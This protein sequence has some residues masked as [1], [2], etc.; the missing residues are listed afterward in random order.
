MKQLKPREKFLIGLLMAV[1][2][3]VL[4]IQLGGDN[5]FVGDT[6]VAGEPLPPVGESPIVRMDLLAVDA[7]P[8]DPSGRNLFAYYVPPKPPPKKRP[9]RKPP[10]P[11]V[12]GSQTAIVVGPGVKP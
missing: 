5:P 8:Y 4:Y 2:V 11:T 6:A 9:P 1:G 12:R 10:R 3:V 7:E